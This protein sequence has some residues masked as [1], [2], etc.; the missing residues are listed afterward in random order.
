MLNSTFKCAPELCTSLQIHEYVSRLRL[1][2]CSVAFHCEY[3]VLCMTAYQTH[4]RT[5]VRG[6]ATWF[7]IAYLQNGH[8]HDHIR[9][10]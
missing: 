5:N 10:W 7:G 4:D 9:M 2:I 6:Q 1:F 3:T 8:R